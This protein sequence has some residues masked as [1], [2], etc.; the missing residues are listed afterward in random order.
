MSVC[1]F[2]NRDMAQ[3]HGCD[4]APVYHHGKKYRPIK[5]GDPGDFY[6][7]NTEARCG[8]CGAMYGHYHHANCD[9]ERCPVCGQQLLIC[10]C[11]DADLAYFPSPV[12]KA[13]ATMSEVEHQA[14]INLYN[15]RLIEGCRST[16][17]TPWYRLLLMPIQKP[18]GS[19][20]YAI[21]QITKVTTTF[22][23]LRACFVSGLQYEQVRSD[24]P[25]FDLD[26]VVPEWGKLIRLSRKKVDQLLADQDA[27]DNPWQ[28][29]FQQHK[30]R[31]KIF[32]ILEWF[33]AEQT[34][35]NAPR[36]CCPRCGQDFMA[37][38]AIRNALS[39]HAKVYICDSCGRNEAVR[40]WNKEPIPLEDWS[41]AAMAK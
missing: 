38:N 19:P 4:F 34:N 17:H 1:R 16:D 32:K 22:C 13:P 15:I 35:E 18:N 20:A 41:C 10:G 14:T 39:R 31:E 21:Y 36:R 37:N 8:D 11:N 23:D 25:E 40:D 6:F 26:Y 7:G 2:C 27:D 5:V 33:Y 30:K 24:F 28:T 29:L 3:T 9:L 12:E